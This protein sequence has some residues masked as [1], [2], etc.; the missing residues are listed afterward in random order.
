MSIRDEAGKSKKRSLMVAFLIWVL[1]EFNKRC[2]CGGEG[3]GYEA[4]CDKGVLLVIVFYL[5]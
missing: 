4:V 5:L 1:E 3:V 2:S